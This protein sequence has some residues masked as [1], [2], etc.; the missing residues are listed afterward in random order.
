MFITR[1]LFV[2]IGVGLLAGCSSGGPPAES[3]DIAKVADVKTSFGP[4]FKVTDVPTTGID[5]KVLAGQKLPEGL[6]FDPAGCAKFAAG[7]ALPTDLKGNMAAV[8]AEGAGNRFIV[9]AMETSEPVPVT[10]PGTDCQKVGFTG[11]A[12]RGAVEVVSAPQIASVQTQG[13]HRIL[14]TTINGKPQTGE[15]FSYLAHFGDYQ[16]IVTVNPLVVPDK[17]VAPADTKRAEDL[18][19]SAVAAIKR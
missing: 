14:Q 2:V 6:V 11:G 9:I 1:A 16:V 10:G 17:P 19:S 8:T 18:L 4:E 3:A 5:P 7:Q 12:L 13:V 15:I